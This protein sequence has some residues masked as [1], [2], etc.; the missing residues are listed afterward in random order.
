MPAPLYRRLC[1]RCPG[2][3]VSRLSVLLCLFIFYFS[4][5]LGSYLYCV[6]HPV[7][8]LHTVLGPQ[9]M[10]H[11]FIA[12]IVLLVTSYTYVGA[13]GCF[14]HVY[15]K[16]REDMAGGGRSWRAEEQEPPGARR[17]APDGIDHGGRGGHTR[18]Q[19]D[20][21]DTS[22]GCPRGA[23]Q[24][25]GAGFQTP[26]SLPRRR[27]RRQR[28]HHSARDS[29]DRDVPYTRPSGLSESLL[30]GDDVN[31][32][33]DSQS[34]ASWWTARGLSVGSSLSRLLCHL[35][36]CSRRRVLPCTPCVD[37]VVPRSSRS[38]LLVCVLFFALVVWLQ[39]ATLSPSS[40]GILHPPRPPAPCLRV[41]RDD[42]PVS[43]TSRGIGAS[44]VYFAQGVVMAQERHVA[45]ADA[46]RTW[47]SG[48]LQELVGPNPLRRQTST[49]S[50]ASSWLL[51]AQGQRQSSPYQTLTPSVIEGLDRL[52]A[53]ASTHTWPAN[54][55]LGARVLRPEAWVRREPWT[56]GR[57]GGVEPRS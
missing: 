54:P 48:R 35:R 55:P 19:P 41:S 39:A 23:A 25:R 43:S 38:L 12:L 14:C 3:S 4:F 22:A 15:N 18:T 24:S 27:G 34:L 7:P 9:L 8:H 17:T 50:A 26:R 6:L 29:V 10:P 46:A 47:R 53:P 33:S 30:G 49:A 37:A 20:G 40:A 45:D 42:D 36:Q 5:T 52:R 11:L 51:P 28:G 44:D 57:R 13:L 1:L 56:C 31:N 32:A 21:D 2:C 16:R